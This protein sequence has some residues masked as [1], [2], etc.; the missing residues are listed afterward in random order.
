MKNYELT[1]IVR[2]DKQEEAIKEYKEILAKHGANIVS[3]NNWG[4]K[5]LAYMIDG[6]REG[7]YLFAN[8]E[9]DP[10]V[11]KKISADFGL[12]NKFLRYMFVITDAKSA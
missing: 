3:E 8:L 5:R 10:Q 1:V 12:N 7:Y 6:V 11:V 9:A 2:T 4:Q